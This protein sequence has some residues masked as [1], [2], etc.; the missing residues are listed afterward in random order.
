MKPASASIQSELGSG[1][2]DSDS[3]YYCPTRQCTAYGELADVYETRHELLQPV[4]NIVLDRVL[5]GMKKGSTVLEVGCGCGASLALMNERGFDVV[6]IDFSP[7]M[8][9]SAERLS[10]CKVKCGDFMTHEF[11]K[12][13]DLVFAQAFVHLFPKVSV[14]AVIGRLLGLASF[15][16]FFS[17]TLNAS[18]TEGWEPKDGVMRYRSRYTKPE[19]LSMLQDIS[20]TGVW[21]VDHFEL[22]DPLNKNW[23]DVI[24]TRSCSEL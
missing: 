8:A 18:S 21:T 3:E 15:R 13:F 12:Q 14:G 6:G 5:R 22:M 1:Q 10:G 24:L 16:V 9:A 23:L 4:R 7:V 20:S 2:S 19:L 11:E 17:T